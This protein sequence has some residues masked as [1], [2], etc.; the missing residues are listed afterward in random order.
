MLIQAERIDANR[1]YQVGMLNKV[2]PS[3][4]LMIEA[5]K[6]AERIAS[7]SPMAVQGMKESMV[8]AASLDYSAVDQITDWVQTRVMNSDDRKEGAKA[9][10]EKREVDWP[11]S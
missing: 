8:R 5:E 11:G 4:Q 3:D 1:A 7:L 2:V 10:A 6:V 9:F